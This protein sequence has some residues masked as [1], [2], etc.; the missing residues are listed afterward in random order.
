MIEVEVEV[1]VEVVSS[2][3]K[4]TNQWQNVQYFNS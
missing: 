3:E 1:E 2:D 4:P